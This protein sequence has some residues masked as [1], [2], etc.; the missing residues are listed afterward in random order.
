VSGLYAGQAINQALSN[1]FL[2]KSLIGRTIATSLSAVS[3]AAVGRAVNNGLQPIINKVSGGIVQAW[4]DSADKV[5][6]VV[7]TWTGTGGYNPATPRDNQVSSVPNPAGG[8]TT[9]YKN[10]DILFEDPNGV[11]TLTPG[12]NDT[13]LLSF[14]NRAPGVNADSAVVGPPY[15]SVWTDSQGIPINFGGGGAVAQDNPFSSPY[16]LP[17][18]ADDVSWVNETLA[19]NDFYSS[20]EYSIP[21]VSDQGINIAGFNDDDFFG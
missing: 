18:I 9:I 20:E 16:P 7:S 8:S 2:G 6:N 3:G 19:Y 1:T 12:N 14:Y 17:I 11:V 15:G 21:G 10:G 13:G 4:D 5:K